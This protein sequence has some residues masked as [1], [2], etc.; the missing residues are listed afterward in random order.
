M[1]LY[2]RPKYNLHQAKAHN[3]I[4]WYI[5]RLLLEKLVI[6]SPSS[7]GRI[8][9]WP[10]WD[11]FHNLS[12]LLWERWWVE[13]VAGRAVLIMSFSQDCNPYFKSHDILCLD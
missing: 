1:V 2:T 5:Y 13:E 3:I 12:Q 11:K 4:L 9:T 10:F 6:H 8:L 7:T